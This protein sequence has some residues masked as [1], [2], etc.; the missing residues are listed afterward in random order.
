MV[1]SGSKNINYRNL[2]MII[3]K[4]WKWSFRTLD[5]LYIEKL[6]V[7]LI[8]NKYWKSCIRTLVRTLSKN[9]KNE[10]ILKIEKN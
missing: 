6:Y 9:K 3:I 10:N 1:S 8:V 4:Y 2:V 7:V 5:I